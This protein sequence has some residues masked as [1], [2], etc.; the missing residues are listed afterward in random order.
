MEAVTIRTSR[1]KPEGGNLDDVQVS[2]VVEAI[3]PATGI[4]LHAD[5]LWFSSKGLRDRTTAEAVTQ[6]AA[7]AWA[8]THAEEIAAR[9]A[10]LDAK[11]AEVAATRFFL[12]AVASTPDI[13]VERQE[14]DAAI[15]AKRRL[16]EVEDIGDDPPPAIGRRE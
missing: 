2:C 5:W 8:R 13:R 4:V 1:P 15:A 16:T 9:A 12:E 14:L 11:A 6:E 3:D 10:G 7:Q